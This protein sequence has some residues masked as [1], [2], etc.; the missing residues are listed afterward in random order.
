MMRSDVSRAYFHAQAQR[1]VLVRL[2]VEN[3][4]KNDPGNIGIGEK[5]HAQHT[6]RRKQ[7]GMRL[8][9]SSRAMGTQSVTRA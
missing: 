9:E 4:G 7:M 8:A 5:A 1:P 3:R 6:G 2:S